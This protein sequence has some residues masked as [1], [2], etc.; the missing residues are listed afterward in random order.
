M[1]ISAIERIWLN[2][3]VFGDIISEKLLSDPH[4]LFLVKVAMF[5]DGSKIP[6]YSMKDTPR[7]ILTKFGSN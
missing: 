7:N 4:V 2:L 3:M 5:F 6:K 1:I